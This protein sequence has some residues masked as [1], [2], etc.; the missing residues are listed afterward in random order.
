MEIKMMLVRLLKVYKLEK[1]ELTPEKLPTT[2]SGVQS[3]KG[4]V[5]VRLVKR[6]A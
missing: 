5:F 4:G 6:D 1:T 2:R 3:P